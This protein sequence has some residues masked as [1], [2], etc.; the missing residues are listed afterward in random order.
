[1]IWKILIIIALIIAVM[2]YLIIRGADLCKT[3]EEKDEEEM[4]QLLFIRK[5]KEKK[6]E[7]IDNSGETECFKRISK[8]TNRILERLIREI[9]T[10]QFEI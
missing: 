10:K 7:K 2:D 4:Q 8:N 3:T 9:L 5:L 1:M 6:N